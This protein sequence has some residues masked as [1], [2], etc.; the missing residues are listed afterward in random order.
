M[1]L[2]T[3]LVSKMPHP[4]RLSPD[5]GGMMSLITALAEKVKPAMFQ[6]RYGVS[7]TEKHQ[8]LVNKSI[9]GMPEPFKGD[10]E[11]PEAV[12][13]ISNALGATKW[14]RGPAELLNSF[15]LGMDQNLPA[16]EAGVRGRDAGLTR[17]KVKE[18]VRALGQSG[19]FPK[20]VD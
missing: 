19:G 6:L 11:N 8:M 10:A 2:G 3:S 17:D 16:Y 20:V 12:R 9:P 4:T 14:G 7:P 5:S 1:R 18:L 15:R 13:Y